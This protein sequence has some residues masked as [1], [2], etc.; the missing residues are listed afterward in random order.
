M[1]KVQPLWSCASRQ[2]LELGQEL[3]QELVL[4]L[5]QVQVLVRAWARVL[6]LMLKLK[7][8]LIWLQEK[9]WRLRRHLGS[10]CRRG[11]VAKAPRALARQ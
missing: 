10:H 2:N 1:P 5:V 7:L 6:M 11:S 4:V 8:K 9:L 3:G